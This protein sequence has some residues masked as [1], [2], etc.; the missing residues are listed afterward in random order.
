MTGVVQPFAF[1]AQQHGRPRAQ[2]VRAEHIVM[3]QQKLANTRRNSADLLL[4]VRPARS[5]TK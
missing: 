3:E 2:T 5:S 1:P 4:A